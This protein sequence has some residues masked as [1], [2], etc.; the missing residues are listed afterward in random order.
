MDIID[1]RDEIGLDREA[2]VLAKEYLG[3]VAWPTVWLGLGVVGAYVATPLAVAAGWLPLWVAVPLMAVLTYAAYTILH[4]SVHGSISGSDSGW[5]WL[6]ELLGYLAAQILMIPLTA[7]RHEH[8]A[9]HRNTNDAQAD[10]DYGLGG[11]GRSPLHAVHCV[12]KSLGGQLGY[13]RRHRWQQGPRSQDIRLCLELAVSI[14][15]RLAFVAQGLWLEG[16]LL[17]VVGGLGGIVLLAYLF[18]YVVHTPHS[19]RGRY[20]D[21]ST[22]L[23]PGPFGQLVTALWGYQNY[24]SIHHLFPRIPFYRYPE[25]FVRLEPT[26]RAMG[27][28]I[29][30]LGRGGRLPAPGPVAASAA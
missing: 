21:T 6:N 12:L 17:F 19:A 16:L 20:V 24:H 27:A 11:M 10:P 7:H 9:H 18:A 23:V 3:G 30:V 5:R 14:L 15:L 4:E 2:R 8:L 13:Y 25:V 1:T 28:P 29:Y 26:M 22:I